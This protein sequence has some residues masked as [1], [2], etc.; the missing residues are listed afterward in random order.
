MRK[1]WL[2]TVELLETQPLLGKKYEVVLVFEKNDNR[3]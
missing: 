2:A 3:P 1:D